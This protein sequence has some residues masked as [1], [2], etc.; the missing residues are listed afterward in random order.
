[1]E[2]LVLICP[3]SSALAHLVLLICHRSLAV[4]HLLLLIRRCGW[5]AVAHWPSCSPDGQVPL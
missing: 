5:S 4:A 2:P 3:F 1:M